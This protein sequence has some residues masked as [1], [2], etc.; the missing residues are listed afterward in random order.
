MYILFQ[1][2][3]RCGM[4]PMLEADVWKLNARE[5]VLEVSHHVSG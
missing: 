3:G 4:H 5:L 1:Q 2:K